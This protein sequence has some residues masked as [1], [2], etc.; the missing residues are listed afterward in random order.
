MEIVRELHGILSEVDP[1]SEL[2]STTRYSD[3]RI[4]YR[5]MCQVLQVRQSSLQPAGRG[6]IGD[7]RRASIST[8][9]FEFNGGV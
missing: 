5:H 1:D 7:Q 9:R 3:A 8:G 6:V 4:F 2:G